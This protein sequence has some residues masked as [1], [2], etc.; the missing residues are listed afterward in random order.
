MLVEVTGIAEADL[1]KICAYL[2]VAALGE[3]LVDDFTS[4]L[5]NSAVFREW[6]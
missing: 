3:D 1:L 2:G 4:Q 5:D 6:V